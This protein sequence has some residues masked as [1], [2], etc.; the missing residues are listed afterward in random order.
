M[1]A[2]LK[3]ICSVISFAA[4]ITLISFG[5]EMRGEGGDVD[6]LMKALAAAHVAR[7]PT[8]AVPPAVYH[9]GRRSFTLDEFHNMEIDAQG[10]TFIFALRG[11]GVRLRRCRN[12]TLKNIYLDMEKPP[13]IQGTIR[14]V[15]RRNRTID[16]AVDDGFPS[17]AEAVF[18]TKRARH[19]IMDADGVHEMP[20][21]DA[22]C[23]PPTELK[24][25]LLRARVNRLFGKEGCN[26]GPGNKIV[27]NMR[28]AGGGISVYESSAVTLEDVTVYAAGSFA[29]HEKGR[30]EGGNLYRRCKLVPR[31]GSGSIWAGAADAFH[32][33]SQKRGPRLVDCEFSRAFDDL[34][35]IHGFINLVMEK[36][37]DD[38]LLLAGPFGQDFDP[39]DT[40][41]FY[42]YPDAVPCGEAEVVSVTALEKPSVKEVEQRAAAYFADLVSTHN[43][44]RSFHG[45][46]VLVKLDRP[47]AVKAFDLAVASTY[48]CRGAVIENCHLHHGHVRGILIK[49]PEATLRNCTIEHIHRYGIVLFAEQYW[50]EGPFPRGIEI[51]NNTLVNC[52][53]SS[54]SESASL[55]AFSAFGVPR[56]S[57]AHAYNIRDITISGNTV[58]DAPGIAVKLANV[59]GARIENNTFINPLCKMRQ[60]Q[61]FDLTADIPADVLNDVMRTPYYGIVTLSSRNVQCNGNRAENTPPFWRDMVGV[62]TWSEKIEVEIPA[63]K[64]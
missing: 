7:N 56:H 63:E 30:A 38:T 2:N 11:G 13:F 55:A 25:G 49:S 34:I 27:I 18:P 60:G 6:A 64:Q 31:P 22:I 57:L 33:M 62:G 23:A 15:D 54:L 61:S 39:G 26:F 14:S 1:P 24:S 5:A 32:S 28:G 35:N 10:S 16:F 17:L 52:G 53:F 36:Q 21:P 4:L 19:V 58:R 59:D 41:R 44:V 48:A 12:L 9:F 50:M 42:H 45:A 43:P 29:F 8:F 46:P 51:L 20:L 37:S 47:V 40:L 3:T